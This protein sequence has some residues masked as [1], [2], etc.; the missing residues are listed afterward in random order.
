MMSDSTP[1]AIILLLSLLATVVL[2][3]CDDDD[4]GNDDNTNTEPGFNLLVGIAHDR[5]F[6][7]E[8]K[9]GLIDSPE[10]KFGVGIT[11]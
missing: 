2:P 1:I 4:G 9:L 11:F 3:S 7:A 6:F 10:V 5:G 8:F